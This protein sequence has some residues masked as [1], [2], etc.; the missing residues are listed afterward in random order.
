MGTSVQIKIKYLSNS[1]LS[2]PHKYNR[3]VDGALTVKTSVF[4]T[5]NIT[6]LLAS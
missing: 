3:V 4:Q 5:Q 2:G 6:L 1:T